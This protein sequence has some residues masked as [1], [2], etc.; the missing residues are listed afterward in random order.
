MEKVYDYYYNVLGRKGVDNNRGEFHMSI[1]F[2]IANSYSSGSGN[3][4]VF[5][6]KPLVLISALLH[7]LV[8]TLHQLVNEIESFNMCNQSSNT[9]ILFASKL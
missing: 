1:N 4:I 9:Y 7:V 5:G 3:N 6:K 2:G 8:N